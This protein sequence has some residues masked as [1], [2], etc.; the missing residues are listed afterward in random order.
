MWLK[1]GPVVRSC[2]YDNE[3]LDSVKGTEF[4]E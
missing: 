4:F 3:L 2:E 1:I